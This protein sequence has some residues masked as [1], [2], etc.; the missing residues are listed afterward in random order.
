MGWLNDPN[1]LCQKDG[2][3]HIYFQYCPFYPVRGSIFWGHM[4][5]RDFIR[6]EE[7]EPVLYPD[8]PWDANGPY[9][10]SAYQEDGTLYVFYTGNVRYED[11][12]YD[13]VNSGREQN[14]ILTVSRDGFCF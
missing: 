5:T 2:I 8:S 12:D 6:Y 10:G 11:G 3:Y 9:S 4:T 14:T 13:Y 1:G 7:Q